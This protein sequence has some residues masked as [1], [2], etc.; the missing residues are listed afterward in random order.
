MY[1]FRIKEHVAWC[2]SVMSDINECHIVDC[3]ERKTALVI[4]VFVIDFCI[5]GVCG[6]HFT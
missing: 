4:F 5:I 6:K 3:V 2:A 1:L